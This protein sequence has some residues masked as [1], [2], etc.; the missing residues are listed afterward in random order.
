MPTYQLPDPDVKYL[1]QDD[2]FQLL[3]CYTTPEIIVPKG[4][5]SDGN[6]APWWARLLYP[7]YGADFPACIVHDWCYGGNMLRKRADQLLR[8]NMLRLGISPIRTWLMY[9][10]VRVGGRSHYER[11][12]QQDVSE[13]MAAPK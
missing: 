4:F 5:I 6:S 9:L 1:I 2:K 7:R 11:R 12:Q 10:A 3:S 13:C 8:K